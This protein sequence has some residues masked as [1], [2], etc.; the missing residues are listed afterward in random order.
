M[1][2]QT[3]PTTISRLHL[4]NALKNLRQEWQEAIDGKSLIDIHTSV[5]LLLVDVVMSIGLDTVEQ[6]Q[7]FGADLSTELDEVL[8]S[9]RN[10]GRN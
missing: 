6:I 8:K 5:G 10:N 4:V 1:L 2:T 7:V 3:E 9:P